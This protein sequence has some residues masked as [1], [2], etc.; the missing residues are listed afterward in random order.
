MIPSTKISPVFLL[1]LTLLLPLTAG[2]G[3]ALAASTR[4]LVREGNQAYENQDFDAALQKYGAAG[5][6]DPD[7]PYVQYNR[8]N[9]LYRRQDYAAAAQAYEKAIGSPDARL[10]GQAHYNLGNSY[11]RQAEQLQGQD[12]QQA[13]GMLDRSLN[14]FR[15]ALADDPQLTPAARNLEI[16]R[17]TKQALE[18][19]VAEQQ[20]RQ[21]ARQEMAEKLQDL[22]DQQQAAAEQAAG[23]KQ[24][25][26]DAATRKQQQL[27]DQSKQ[28]ADQLDK[29]AQASP[30]DK[31]TGKLD[32]AQGHLNRAREE[33]E[34]AVEDLQEKRFAQA[35]EEQKA[36]ADQLKQ[37]GDS[38]KDEKPPAEQ[39]T[40]NDQAQNP[41]QDKGQDQEK[42]SGA[43]QQEQGKDQEKTG[44]PAP[45]DQ[46]EAEAARP[47][48][49]LSARDLL[50]REK[51]N[52]QQRAVITDG[53]GGVAVDK[54]W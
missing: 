38:L 5:E 1:M 25:A 34:K 41:E 54:D 22:A 20:A 39:K 10:S 37:A 44:P 42:Q 23:R 50:E 46:Q 18:K 31:D 11:Y 24:A 13:L 53:P 21:Q 29:L 16:A 9:A 32:K 26:P 45:A 8:G 27:N 4:Q 14:H 28:L 15:Q 47:P 33:Q 49:G 30:D 40:E 7:S 2:A 6:Q 3:S 48:Q 43:D 12:P 36:A 51:I 19:Q 52:R 35:A 17:R